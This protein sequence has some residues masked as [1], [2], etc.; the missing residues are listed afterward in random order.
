MSNHSKSL[1]VWEILMATFECR[2]LWNGNWGC[3]WYFKEYRVKRRCKYI[4]IVQI[5]K[6]LRKV[7]LDSRYS[8]QLYCY[9]LGRILGLNHSIDSKCSKPALRY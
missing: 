5:I 4:L 6:A 8:H 1:N 9:Y 2:K 7:R 3:V